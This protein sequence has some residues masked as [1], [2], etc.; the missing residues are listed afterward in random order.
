MLKLYKFLISGIT[1]QSSKNEDI[2]LV[3]DTNLG[4]EHARRFGQDGYTTYYAV[5]HGQ[6]YPKMQD[7]ICG[8]GFSDV[9]K[10]WD[11][12]EGL[13]KGANIIVFTDSGFGH[14]ASWLRKEGYY[15][16][17]ADGKSERLELDRVYVRKVLQ[18]LGIDVPPGKVVRG[19]KQVVEAVRNARGKVFVKINRYRGTVETF[20]TDDPAEAEAILSR[21]AFKILGDNVTFV[22]ENELKGVEIG[23]D[24]W[25]NGRQFIP[26]VA[27]TIEYQ[28]CG[29]TTKFVKLQ[30]S[31]WYDV[32]KRLEPW[33]A[34]NGYVGMFCLEGFYDGK[35]IYVTDITPR[36][37]YICSYAYPKV[38][39]N[40]TEFMIGVAKGSDITP[41][42][43]GKYSVQIGVYTDDPNTWRV[44]HYNRDD[45]EWIAYRRVIKRDDDIWFV[46]GDYVVAV[47]IS[48][49]DDLKTAM[50][51]AIERASAVETSNI[52][53]QGKEFEVYLN[54]VLSKA[55][56]LGY[57]F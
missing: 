11:W 41:E 20:G 31:I 37:S 16:I 32:L 4:L 21:G 27:E 33:L 28:G 48:A 15:V 14:L 5:V 51:Q 24:A 30:D 57:T 40:Y 23:V 56:K 18:Q 42:P 13:E 19:V 29:N 10:I 17:G 46:P 47:G 39:K 54:D 45:T 2:I 44:I 8:Y 6:P 53:C 9:R 36:F 55:K 38:I 22:V 25:F 7:E 35:T 49:A 12:G 52:Y 3:V 43:L 50:K 1:E 26:I 34:K